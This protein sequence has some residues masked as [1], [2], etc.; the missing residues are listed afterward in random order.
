MDGG[1]T[2][3]SKSVKVSSNVRNRLIRMEQ[4]RAAEQ[5]EK[6]AA[7]VRLTRSREKMMRAPSPEPYQHWQKFTSCELESPRWRRRE[8]SSA[9]NAQDPMS[10]HPTCPGRQSKVCFCFSMARDRSAVATLI[11][12]RTV[13]ALWFEDLPMVSVS[14]QRE[15]RWCKVWVARGVRRRGVASRSPRLRILLGNEV[16]IT[17]DASGQ[18]RAIHADCPSTVAASPLAAA[19]G[20]V[21]G[22][23][24]VALTT[25]P[26]TM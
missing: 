12:H 8:K 21:H 5:K 3:K 17:G 4:E 18:G 20:E 16:L 15:I 25:V 14:I 6:D 7:Q 9:R 2:F 23:R 1:S 26:R 11:D 24:A 10:L 19:R 13:T 22:V